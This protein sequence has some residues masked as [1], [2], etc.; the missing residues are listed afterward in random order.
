MQSSS[1]PHLVKQREFLLGQKE[2]PGER[3]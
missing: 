2:L 3:R 1:R